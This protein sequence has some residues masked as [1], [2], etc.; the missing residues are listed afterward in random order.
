MNRMRRTS[1]LA[2]VGVIGVGVVIGRLTP[3]VIVRLGEPVPRVPWLA[4]V[5]IGFAALVVAVLAWTTWQALHRQQRQMASDRGVTLVAVAKSGVSVGS[6]VGGFYG[7]FSVA[8]L[9]SL[10]A[11]LGRERALH[12]AV[13]AVACLVLLIAS[14][15]LE[16]ACEV[17][18]DDEDDAIGDTA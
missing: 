17:P 10:D 8:Y 13:A 12:A 1:L 16:R 11:V 14:L 3:P 7:G 6:L 15:L 4:P 9:G 5:L 18:H 2:V